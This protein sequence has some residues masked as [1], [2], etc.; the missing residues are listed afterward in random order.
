MRDWNGIV[1]VANVSVVG[2]GREV[3]GGGTKLPSR[4]DQKGSG[5]AG[6]K[7]EEFGIAGGAAAGVEAAGIAS[8]AGGDD[9]AGAAGGAE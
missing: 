2:S 7:A 4:W 6:G 5:L 9:M 1:V 3:A 8:G